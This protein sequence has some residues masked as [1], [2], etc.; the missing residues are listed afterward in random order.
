ML[1][2]SLFKAKSFTLLDRVQLR[3]GEHVS[4][5]RKESGLYTAPAAQNVPLSHRGRKI[6]TQ[7]DRFVAQ[8]ALYKMS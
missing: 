4:D 2:G 1:I 8:E 6:A 7:G 5:R 3:R